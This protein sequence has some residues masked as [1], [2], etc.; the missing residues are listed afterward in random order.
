MTVL[1]GDA[2]SHRGSGYH[3]HQNPHTV[4]H[5]GQ[6]SHHG[7]PHHRAAVTLSDALHAAPSVAASEYDTL[8]R[9]KARLEDRNQPFSLVRKEILPIVNSLI[10]L[11][12]AAAAY[13]AHDV[14]K[15][16]PSVIK[17]FLEYV[18]G[19]FQSEDPLAIPNFIYHNGVYIFQNNSFE[20]FDQAVSAINRQLHEQH[21]IR[22]D[23][24]VGATAFTQLLQVSWE[25]LYHI[26]F[27]DLRGD[28]VLVEKGLE[29]MQVLFSGCVRS[30]NPSSIATRGA[31]HSYFEKIA[32]CDCDLHRR[33]RPHDGPPPQN[34]DEWCRY[35]DQNRTAVTSGPYVAKVWQGWHPDNQF[36]PYDTE[37]AAEAR[38]SY[39]WS[40]V[41]LRSQP[42]ISILK[43]IVSRKRLTFIA[44]FH[45][46]QLQLWMKEWEKNPLR[47][48]NNPLI[49]KSDQAEYMWVLFFQHGYQAPWPDFLEAFEF[50]FLR[51]KC[52]LDIANVLKLFLD[53]DDSNTVHKSSWLELWNSLRE[54]QTPPNFKT[55]LRNLV[56]IVLHSFSRPV[57]EIFPID[58]PN[59]HTH[60]YCNCLVFSDFDPRAML[61][62]AAIFRD[63]ETRS[64]IEPGGCLRLRAIRTINSDLGITDRFMFLKIITGDLQ[65]HPR[66]VSSGEFLRFIDDPDRSATQQHGDMSALVVT[67]FNSREL[68][69]TK[70][71]RNSTRKTILPDW[72]MSEPIASRSHFSV[73]H[74]NGAGCYFTLDAGSKWGTFIKV[75]RNIELSCGDWIRV[76]GVEFVVRYSGGGCHKAGG[77][78]RKFKHALEMARPKLPISE[79]SLE[80]A[81][82]GRRVRNRPDR[83]I[84]GRNPF[85]DEDFEENKKDFPNDWQ[86]RMGWLSGLS[87]QTPASYGWIPPAL[88]LN[89]ESPLRHPLQRAKLVDLSS[90]GHN[91][92]L[93]Q[94]QAVVGDQQLDWNRP[95]KVVPDSS[96][97]QHDPIPL[98]VA[99][100]APLEIEFISGP[101]MGEHIV[102]SQKA[103]T[104]GRAEGNTITVNDAQLASV[105]RTHCTIFAFISWSFGES[106]LYVS[107]AYF[108]SN[109]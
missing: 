107:M 91:Q 6:E 55:L 14:C 5:H 50:F 88:E 16:F 74:K 82:G 19:P 44:Q 9:L 10:C 65:S 62:R 27:A 45:C 59:H 72:A 57:D 1:D 32:S 83:P 51:E 71:G 93:T 28:P 106:N 7:V 18:V 70:F 77:H 73:I 31:L 101:R 8:C 46:D 109:R 89:N 64:P 13:Q 53:S 67:P 12:E 20:P 21:G 95:V 104:L 66:A 85:D 41:R 35:C 47:D 76:G 54:P 29:R 87:S 48:N 68:G 15:S 92:V 30:E 34:A 99:P 102:I 38:E 39:S 2:Y 49:A 81:W 98:Q 43:D 58:Q 69:V 78:S 24:W 94:S 26:V 56:K 84:F 37:A 33:Q 90:D 3:L 96:S 75:A 60:R 17:M 103:A 4:H 79:S 86:E 36:S 25:I 100:V 52:P 105:S 22:S 11:W 108:C 63:Q 97:A 42:E 61:D 40:D 80:T 23:I